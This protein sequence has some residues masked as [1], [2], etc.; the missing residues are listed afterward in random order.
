MTG[1]RRRNGAPGHPR[2]QGKIERLHQSLKRWLGVPPH[3]QT[4]SQLKLMLDE[5]IGWYN[6]DARTGPWA[7]RPQKRPTKPCRKR[8][9]H[10]PPGEYRNHGDRVDASGKVIIRYVAQAH[11]R[12]YFSRPL[13]SVKPWFAVFSRELTDQE[14]RVQIIV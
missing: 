8:P 13:K 5:F 7:G 9:L 14:R 10:Q 11:F 3:T 1:S 2:T 12:M 6:H 4:L